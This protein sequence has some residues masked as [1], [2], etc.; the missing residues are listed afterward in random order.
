ME[1]DVL[2]TGAGFFCGMR[3]FIND[4]MTGEHIKRSWWERLFSWPWRPWVSTKFNPCGGKPLIEDGQVFRMSRDYF[5]MN[6][7]TKQQLVNGLKKE[8]LNQH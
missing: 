5:L 2:G 1:D 7:R 3:I 8:N 4:S 6:S